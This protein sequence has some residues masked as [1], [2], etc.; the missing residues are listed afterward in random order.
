MQFLSPGEIVLKTLA[1]LIPV[2]MSLALALGYFG[3]GMPPESP[4][5]GTMINESSRFMRIYVHPALPPALALMS[6]VLG[7]NLLADAIR[8]QSLRD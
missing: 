8:E 1:Q 6:F 4:N 5:W 7:L 2:W 3:L